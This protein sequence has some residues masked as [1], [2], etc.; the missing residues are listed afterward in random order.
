MEVPPTF[1]CTSHLCWVF[2]GPAFW[3]NGFPN[4]VCT[5]I[6]STTF[7]GVFRSCY[8][9]QWFWKFCLYILYILSIFLPVTFEVFWSFKP[10]QYFLETISMCQSISEYSWDFSPFNLCNQGISVEDFRII[11]LDDQICQSGQLYQHRSQHMMH[12]FFPFNLSNHRISFIESLS[13]IYNY[14]CTL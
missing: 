14:M 3:I 13:Y 10:F 1:V 8:M 2:L 9:N 7:W 12:N 5:Y 11:F 6:P 4:L